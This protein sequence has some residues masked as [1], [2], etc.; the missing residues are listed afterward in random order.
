MVGPGENQATP[1]RLLLVQALVNTWDGD[2][3]PTYSSAR[4]YAPVLAPHQVRLVHQR[5]VELALVT[6]S[7]SSG[8]LPHR[9]PRAQQRRARVRGREPVIRR[10]TASSARVGRQRRSRNVSG[11]RARVQAA[12]PV[13]KLDQCASRP[14]AAIYSGIDL[15]SSV[16]APCSL[17]CPG[18]TRY[19]P[20]VDG[21]PPPQI[22]GIS[23]AC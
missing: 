11:T 7:V 15:Y 20:Y 18:T 16:F 13:G 12:F 21:I 3:R 19:M 4:D 10:R 14:G 9:V 1:G 5:C 17:G 8:L 23:P 22:A 2:A 6:G